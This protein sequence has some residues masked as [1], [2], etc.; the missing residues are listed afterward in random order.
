MALNINKVANKNKKDFG[1]AKAGTQMSRLVRIIDLGLQARPDYDGQPK[2][3]AYMIRL[4]FELPNDRIEIDGETRPRWADV[5]FPISSHEKSKCYQWYNI[6]D[7]ENK[8]QGD[9]SKLI[10]VPCL[11]VIKHRESKG[12]TYANIANVMPTMDG[13]DVPELENPSFVFDLGSPDIER[14]KLLPDWLQEKIKMNLEFQNSKLDRLLSDLPV[15]A[16][17]T[18]GNSLDEV[19]E[20]DTSKK[21]TKPDIEVSLV[22]FDD[23]IP[24]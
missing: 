8:Y 4:T 21:E 3:P 19:A 15:P 1:V 23:D 12:K 20:I 14:F 13:I 10:A 24:F 2:Q 16:T 9:W 17:A 22:D 18:T 5:E 6:L 7:P 11:L